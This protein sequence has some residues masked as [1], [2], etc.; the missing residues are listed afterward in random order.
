MLSQIIL[1]SL[2][3]LVI[4]TILDFKY[5]QKSA[6]KGGMI[7]SLALLGAIYWLTGTI[8]WV[9][10]AGCCLLIAMGAISLRKSDNLFFK[11]QP[12]IFNL[13]LATGL[14][15]FFLASQQ[16]YFTYFEKYKPML[17]E[18][19][20]ELKT[21]Q[22]AGMNAYAHRPPLQE[23]APKDGT[24]ME[25]PEPQMDVDAWIAFTVSMI[26]ALSCL[27]F[28][29]SCLQLY[30]AYRCRTVTWLLV[31]GLQLPFILAGIF[32]WINLRQ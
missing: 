1:L 22:E 24:G 32:V 12:G 15:A 26:P 19:L 10:V 8:D 17:R 20:A 25:P 6:V 23:S 5:S 9:E 2:L 16:S 21:G 13:L 11:L 31:K 29:H 28:I 7:T 3:P 14:A 27:L 18:A 30:A 4:F